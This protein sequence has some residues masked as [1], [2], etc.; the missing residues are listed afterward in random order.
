MVTQQRVA[1]VGAGVSGLVA[2][3]TLAGLGAE[4]I[5]L[6]RSDRPGGQVRTIR[7]AGR[8]VD[9]GAEALHLAGPHVTGLLDELGL[10]DSLVS[11]K[12]TWTWI[13]TGRGL[14]RLPAGVGPA[15]PTRLAPLVTSGVLGPLGLARAALE[16]LVPRR[17]VESDVSVGDFLGRRFGQQVV[18]RL[19]DPLLGS[20][21]AG[22]VS[23][24]SLRAAT[25]YLAATARERRSLVLGGRGR[26]KS[27]GTSFVSFP[28]GLE[29]LVE[30]LAGHPEVDLRTHSEVRTLHVDPAGSTN[31]T[32]RLGLSD[33]ETIDADA[34]VLAV[35]AHAAAAIL[36]D[37]GDPDDRDAAAGGVTAGLSELRAASVATVLAAFPASEVESL[38]AFG[39]TG[40][41]VPSSEGRFLKAATF[42]SRK[43]EHL[44]DP[45]VFLVRMSAGRAGDEDVTAL[46]DEV[47][48]ERLTSNLAAATG[49]GVEP[50]AVHVHRWPRAM[51][52][53]EVG[54]LDRIGAI[55][56]G[57]AGKGTV[58]LAGAP[59]EGVGLASCI[60][61]GR[62]AA[63]RVTDP[64]R[65]TDP[66]RSG[67]GART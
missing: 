67:I 47:L 13:W 3:R 54:H 6:E 37:G 60:R 8:C 23:R 20:L 1:V 40:I 36:G 27:I 33:G 9:V 44:E 43:W 39:A 19:V 22:D 41:L 45:E 18:Q 28:G 55:R 29:T 35:P 38:P 42:L 59:F 50:S 62:A 26:S 30:S 15:G 66:A 56:A 48:T 24:L 61:S 49:L 53:L 32:V 65:I 14:R 17:S 58:A 12:A 57:L 4:V 31:P 16:P 51:A 5:V 63:D 21:H 25:P 52:Q 7:F 10:R 34:A 46:S 64:A 2:A 11:A